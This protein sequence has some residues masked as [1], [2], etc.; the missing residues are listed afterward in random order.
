MS[1]ESGFGASLRQMIWRLI[2]LLL[3]APVAWAQKPSFDVASIK[4][5]ASGQD[6]GSIGPRG[7]AFFAS[8]VTL[9]SLMAYAYSPP[10][11]AFLRAQ[12]VGA[13]AWIDTDRYD[14]EAKAG[15]SER[16]PGADLRVM[17]QSLLEDRFQLKAHREMRELPVYNLVV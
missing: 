11:G 4:P 9:E 7:G 6:G 14:I 10:G 15:G 3:M 5:N 13:P 8:N 16:V 12:I 17:V 2:P 1:T